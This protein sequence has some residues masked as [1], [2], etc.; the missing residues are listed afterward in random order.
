MKKKGVFAI[1]LAL[2]LAIG[3]VYAAATATGNFSLTYDQWNRSSYAK[4]EASYPYAKYTAQS[5]GNSTLRITLSQKNFL[6]LGFDNKDVKS[7]SISGN[8]VSY[9]YFSKQTKN[10]D[11]LI[12]SVNTKADSVAN[13]KYVLTSKSTAGSV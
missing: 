5:S 3:C 10:K 1:V 2:T 13:A 7:I 6:G 12:T 11:Y 8:N 4:L 9:A